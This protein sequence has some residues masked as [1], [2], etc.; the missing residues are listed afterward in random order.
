MWNHVC[1]VFTN[2][3]NALYFSGLGYGSGTDDEG[4]NSA[5]DSDD[6]SEDEYAVRERIK[7]KRAAFDR[8][9]REMEE[10][11]G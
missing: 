9:M 1:R 11:G 2:V 10:E 4:Q 7:R 6:E 8:K 3:T 5:E